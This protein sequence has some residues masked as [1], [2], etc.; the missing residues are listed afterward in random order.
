M[1]REA[2][3]R[4]ARVA[5]LE[6]MIE[7][8]E[9]EEKELERQEG[10]LSMQARAELQDKHREALIALFGSDDPVDLRVARRFLY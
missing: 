6:D 4:K 7:R 5:A 1:R 3:M 8:Q 10:Q 2:Q 9:A